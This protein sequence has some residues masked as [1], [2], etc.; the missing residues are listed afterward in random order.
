MHR[1]AEINI[2]RPVLFV[3]SVFCS[4]QKPELGRTRRGAVGVYAFAFFDHTWSGHD[5]DLSSSKS[6]QVIFVLKYTNAVK[7]GDIPPSSL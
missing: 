5:S 7:F 2:T 1:V 4:Y 3:Y 6:N